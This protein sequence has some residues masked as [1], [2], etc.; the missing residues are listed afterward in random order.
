[1]LDIQSYEGRETGLVVYC[2]EDDF[3][4]GFWL[5]DLSLRNAFELF[6]KLPGERIS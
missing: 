4:I 1:V 6:Q 2:S 5:T 3:N